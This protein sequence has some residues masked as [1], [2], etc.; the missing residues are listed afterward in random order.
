MLLENRI[1]EGV[2]SG[3]LKNKTAREIFSILKLR[4]N[5]KKKL[6]T[7]LLKLCDNGELFKTPHGGFLTPEQAGAFKG[8]LRGNERGFAFIT[9]ESGGSDY[10][11]PRRSVNGAYDGDSVLAVHVPDT[12]DEAL[13]VRVWN[14]GTSR[15]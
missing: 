7:L 5:E 2:K 8:T 4:Q 3:R 11:V 6:K 14:A 13:V 12:R 9:P 15:L 1:L 10:F